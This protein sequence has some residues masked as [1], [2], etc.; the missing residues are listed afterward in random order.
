MH[1]FNSIGL[2]EKLSFWFSAGAWWR[3][4]DPCVCGFLGNAKNKFNLR[5]P[6][7][8]DPSDSN[9]HGCSTCPPPETYLLILTLVSLNKAYSPLISEG[10]T[11]GGVGWPIFWFGFCA[12]GNR[13]NL[14]EQEVPFGRCNQLS[15]FLPRFVV[16]MKEGRW[17]KQDPRGPTEWV[18]TVMKP[19]PLPFGG[20]GLWDLGVRVTLFGCRRKMRK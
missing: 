7:W 1:K 11:L 20:L 15:V 13:F 5:I 2:G 4:I 8:F 16:C 9:N 18:M 10:G 19:V 14:V 17:M 3:S 12:M 6:I